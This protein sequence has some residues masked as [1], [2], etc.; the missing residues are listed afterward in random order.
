MMNLWLFKVSGFYR[1]TAKNKQK[2]V[3]LVAPD[4]ANSQALKVAVS[5]AASN[6]DYHAPVYECEPLAVFPIDEE[7]MTAIVVNDPL[8]TYQGES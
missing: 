4:T 5:Q 8:K 2:R 7:K 6:D 3:A 1:R